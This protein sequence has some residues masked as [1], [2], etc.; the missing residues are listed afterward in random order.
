MHAAI[1]S[2]YGEAYLAF[3]V[4]MFLAPDVMF[5]FNH[6]LGC[7]DCG[8]T[9]PDFKRSGRQHEFIALKR[10]PWRQ[11]VRQGLIFDLSKLTSSHGMF[12]GGSGNRK[13]WL[14]YVNNF[15][16]REQQV[17]GVNRTDVRVAGHIGDGNHINDALCLTYALKVAGSGSMPV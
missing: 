1:F 7:V 2:W 16:V 12:V 9:I 17:A 8:I 11:H 13:D 4:E 10:L 6:V 5:G 3:Q 14:A 15:L